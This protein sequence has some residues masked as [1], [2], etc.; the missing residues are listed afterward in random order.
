MLTNVFWGEAK[1]GRS[2]SQT[3]GFNEGDDIGSADRA[4]F[5]IGGEFADGGGGIAALFAQ[6]EEDVDACLEWAGCGG[7][8]TEVG[9]GLATD[10]ILLIVEGDKHLGGLAEMLGRSVLGEEEV[11]DEEHEVQEGQKL[12]RQVVAGALRVFTIPEAEVEANGDQVGDVVGSGV[13][14]G[15]CRGDDGV[16][17]SQG[18]GLFS[19][20]KG[21]FEPVGLEL[22]CDALVEAGVCLDVGRF[23]GAGQTIQEVGRYNCPPCLKN[24]F[25]LKLVHLALGVL[26]VSNSVA[27]DLKELNTRDGWILESRIDQ[28]GGTGVGSLPVQPLLSRILSSDGSHGLLRSVDITQ[29]S[30]SG[31]RREICHKPCD[32]RWTTDMR[33]IKSVSD[34]YIERKASSAIQFSWPIW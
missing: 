14:G 3:L 28:Q 24:R 7:L 23:F 27:V 26:G 5:I 17:N 6:A 20:D 13:G 34:E 12:D 16:H 22:P 15:S 11:P 25:F 32:W 2:H 9:D 4:E 19:S 33:V 10:S 18:G 30:S 31:G 8:R 1:S 21:I 29:E